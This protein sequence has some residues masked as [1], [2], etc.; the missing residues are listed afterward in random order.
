LVKALISIMATTLPDARR[1][2]SGAPGRYRVGISPP[3]EQES[4]M[5]TCGDALVP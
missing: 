4:L 5:V 2:V 1:R 3:R